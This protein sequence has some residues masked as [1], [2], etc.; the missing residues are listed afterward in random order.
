MATVIADTSPLQYL[1]Q[2]GLVELLRDLFGRVHVPV[3]VRDELQVGRSLGFDVPDP[4]DHP[5]MSVRPTK[6]APAL[7]RFDLGPGEYA[8]LSLALELGEGLVLLDDAAA[9]TAANEL[10]LSTTGTLGILLL[11]KER[12]LIVAV[13]PVLDDLERRGFRIT[14]AVR[15]R[16]LQIAGE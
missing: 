3:A 6:R 7:E 9:R 2:V 12:G 16:V 10:Q 11:A 15:S 1:F 13:T 5:W 4:A 14:D 8:A